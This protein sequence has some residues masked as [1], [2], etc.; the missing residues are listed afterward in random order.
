MAQQRIRA[1]KALNL[2]ALL[3]S[4]LVQVPL[5]NLVV[6][7]D[8]SGARLM[9]HGVQIPDLGTTLRQMLILMIKVFFLAITLTTLPELVLEG[10][11]LL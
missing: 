5:S 2:W 11:F 9:S 3:H 4:E 8:L 10:E 7:T 1:W 6:A